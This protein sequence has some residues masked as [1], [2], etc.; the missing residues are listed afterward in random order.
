MA[1]GV[2]SPAES[3]PTA[4]L[5]ATDTT[6]EDNLS[7]SDHEA[8][9][10]ESRQETQAEAET[11][12][13]ETPEPAA[14]D[15][16]EGTDD[17]GP[18]D[19]KGRFLP[20]KRHRAES[21][22]AGPED[23]PR[24][25]QLTARLRAAEAERD[26]LKAQTA[27]VPRDTPVQAPAQATA[28]TRPKP[29]PNEFLAKETDCTVGLAKYIEALSDWKHEQNVAAERQAAQ[30]AQAEQEARRIETSFNERKAAA[31]LKYDDFD[32]VAINA[33]TRIP[34]GSLIDAWV[35]EHKTGADVL[36]HLQK[37]PDD[38][39]AL[40]QQPVLEQ[41][42]ALALLAQRFNGHG[43]TAAAGTGSAPASSHPSAPKPPNPVRTGPLRSGDE[44]PDEEAASLADH[45]KWY[46]SRA[47][48]R[49]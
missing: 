8:R 14:V 34:I 37:H 45:E 24:I 17:A 41:A 48:R 5:P 32:A 36:Y 12:P 13:V 16:A 25:Q 11:R 28:P 47:R 21:A 38:L 6:P 19:E 35:M 9:Y 23:V 44:P 33:P 46:A 42:E 39:D 18:R 30:Q 27:S 22:I 20:K 29:D 4:P 31:R 3:V 43:R 7:L 26:A 49:A 40:L 15:A 2:S 10:G 1:E